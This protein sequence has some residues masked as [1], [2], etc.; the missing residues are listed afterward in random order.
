MKEKNEEYDKNKFLIQIK[1]FLLFIAPIF[2]A[3]V[4]VY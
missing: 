1:Y 3:S 4:I 2:M